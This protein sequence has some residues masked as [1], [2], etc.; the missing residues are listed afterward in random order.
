MPASEAA[1]H[2]RKLNHPVKA[3]STDSHKGGLPKIE[4]FLGIR[5]SNVIVSGIKKAEGTRG[6]VVRLYETDGK[7]AR[8][9]IDLNTKLMSVAKSVEETD[10]LERPT[11]TNSAKFAKGKIS[12]NVPAFGIATVLIKQ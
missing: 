1:M 10:L 2:G 5:P 12:V 11:K 3:V 9:E 8:A 7:N 6:L 4:S